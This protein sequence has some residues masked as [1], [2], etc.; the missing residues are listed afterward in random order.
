MSDVPKPPTRPTLKVKLGTPEPAF[1]QPGDDTHPVAEPATQTDVGE[2]TS[3]TLSPRQD[4]LTPRQIKV[5]LTDIP[6]H[7]VAVLDGMSHVEAWDIRAH[8]NRIFGFGRWSGDVLTAELLY[9]HNTETRAGKAAFKVA[10]RVVYRLTVNAPDGTLLATYTEAAVGESV[11]PDFKRG[12]A[13]D[14][15]LKTAE[16]QALKRCATNLGTQ[17]GLS[18]YNEGQLRDVVLKTLVGTGEEG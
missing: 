8:L 14:M 9:E 4:Y 10:Y 1:T 17:F 6:A 16:S 12:D 7:R 2:E 3:P 13:H 18:L 11:M 5:L 15:A